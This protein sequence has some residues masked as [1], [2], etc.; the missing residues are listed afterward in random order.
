MQV[1]RLAGEDALVS[2]VQ[3]GERVVVDGQS[4][5]VPGAR[6]ASSTPRAPQTAAA[7]SIS[8]PFIRR[9]IG[10]A[11]LTIGLAFFGLLAYLQLAG[12]RS[13]ERRFSDDLR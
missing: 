9:P 6:V 8:E 1:A 11:L 4:R 10:T 13:A 2:G 12:L 7:L 3:P 5:L